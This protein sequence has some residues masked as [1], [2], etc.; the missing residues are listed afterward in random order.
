M[1]CQL[2]VYLFVWIKIVNQPPQLCPSLPPCGVLCD[3]GANETG[4][5]CLS[6]GPPP[7][8]SLCIYQTSISIYLSINQPQL[9]T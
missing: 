9:L 6:D 1:C 5:L 2:H 8:L 3:Q 4:H 7:C